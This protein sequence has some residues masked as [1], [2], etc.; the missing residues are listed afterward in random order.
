MGPGADLGG[1]G[2]CELIAEKTGAQMERFF[3]KIGIGNRG[4]ENC[5]FFGSEIGIGIDIDLAF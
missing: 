1:G 3:K 2:L 5:R 4:R